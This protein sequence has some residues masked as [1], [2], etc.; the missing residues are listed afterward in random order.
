M[1]LTQVNQNISV[2]L[3]G[4]FPALHFLKKKKNS[5]KLYHPTLKL[6]LYLTVFLKNFQGVK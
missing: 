5:D 1:T 4:N 6:L 2:S 3:Q